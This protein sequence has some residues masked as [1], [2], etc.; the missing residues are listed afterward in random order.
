MGV[1]NLWPILASVKQEVCV[2][3]LEGKVIAVDLA[4]WLVESQVTGLKVMQ[5]KVLK[6]H[7]RNL[8]FRVSNFLRLGVQLV[9]VIDGTPPELKWE[10]VSRR[11]QAR[12]H[13]RKVGGARGRGNGRKGPSRSH[14]KGWLNECQEMLELMGVPCVQS[15]GEAEAMC[16][17]LDRQGIADG[18]L[19]EDGDAFLYGARTVYRN[20]NMS[21]GKVDRYSMDDI[22]TKLNLNRRRL[23]ALA[24][25]LGCDYLPKGVPGVG[26]EL[27]MKFFM[28]LP[29]TED[30]LV[31][32]QGWKDGLSPDAQAIERDIRKKS[33]KVDG[34]PNQDVINE[35]L[36]DKEREPS[37]QL[38]WKRP[39]L[40]HL[41]H[42]NLTKMDWLMEYTEEKVVPLLTLYDLTHV[43]SNSTTEC[44]QPAAVVKMRVR[45]GVQCVEIKWHKPETDKENEEN[46]NPYYTTIENRDLFASV[47][48]N[49]IQEYMTS[50]E[51][52]KTKRGK[53]KSRVPGSQEKGPS[54]TKAGDSEESDTRVPSSQRQQDAMSVVDREVAG[55]KDTQHGRDSYRTHKGFAKDEQLPLQRSSQVSSRVSSNK[56][57]DLKKAPGGKAE[58]IEE[59]S[60]RTKHTSV[61]PFKSSTDQQCSEVESPQS[62]LDT[63][64]KPLSL[65]ERLKLRQHSSQHLSADKVSK[66]DEKTVTDYDQ[67]TVLQASPRDESIIA[68][69]QDPLHQSQSQTFK[70]INEDELLKK[71]ISLSLDDG[72]IRKNA[73]LRAGH[74]ESKPR[75]E[76]GSHERAEPRNNNISLGNLT[77]KEESTT[78]Y[79]SGMPRSTTTERAKKAWNGKDK[80]SEDDTCKKLQRD[81]SFVEDDVAEISPL[82]ERLHCDRSM[83]KGAFHGMRKDSNKQTTV[84]GDSLPESM[85]NPECLC[86]EEEG[87]SSHN[88]ICGMKSLKHNSRLVESPPSMRTMSQ[89]PGGEVLSSPSARST[90]QGSRNQPEIIDLTGSPSVCAPV[91]LMKVTGCQ[92]PGTEEH[93]FRFADLASSDVSESNDS[94]TDERKIVADAK[95]AKDDSSLTPVLE[96]LTL[97]NSAQGKS[98]ATVMQNDVSFLKLDPGLANLLEDMNFRLSGA[99]MANTSCSQHGDS[100]FIIDDEHVDDVT[101][102]MEQEVLRSMKQKE[103]VPDI[104]IDECQR[105]MM[106][107]S[108]GSNSCEKDR[109]EEENLRKWE[110][111]RPGFSSNHMKECAVQIDSESNCQGSISPRQNDKAVHDCKE[112]KDIQVEANTPHT[113]GSSANEKRQPQESDQGRVD[114][115]TL[116]DMLTAHRKSVSS[117]VETATLNE[118]AA[119]E[120]TSGLHK[121]KGKRKAA[122]SKKSKR[123]QDTFLLE[124]SLARILEG[125]SP[126]TGSVSPLQRAD[127]KLTSS[128]P[129]CN[130]TSLEQAILSMSS[131]STL[132]PTL[133]TQSTLQIMSS[134]ATQSTT[135]PLGQA[136]TNSTPAATPPHN[137]ILSQPLNEMAL[138]EQPAVQLSS[139]SPT[140][141][142]PEVTLSLGTSPFLMKPGGG[143]TQVVNT[144]AAIP[145]VKTKW[146]TRP[147][148]S[149]APDQR[150]TK[151]PMKLRSRGK[152]RTHSQPDSSVP[153]PHRGAARGRKNRRES[154]LALEGS[155]AKILQN[156]SPYQECSKRNYE[157]SNLEKHE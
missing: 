83:G 28:S 56:S 143:V 54:S 81:T 4:I 110:T 119:V 57:L 27:A 17:L 5:G 10:E 157:D 84:S 6:P 77:T 23:V 12:H 39:L 35:F 125:L 67:Q 122:K 32:L 131:P 117:L 96:R 95:D 43:T 11:V 116:A 18:C 139:P 25:F 41:Q 29:R 129:A 140:P 135:R 78:E 3:A 137:A 145:D 53:N 130:K 147:R 16:A 97:S 138:S 93:N 150:R 118:V 106:L 86:M 60:N 22:E 34:F 132:V 107:D 36:L 91:K 101:E 19:T 136:A 9:F 144:P 111:V 26:K 88:H 72:S 40:T 61:Q 99:S 46:T 149:S 70:V 14:F 115:I 37:R 114:R 100:V 103:R 38:Q 79:P 148:I 128:A 127:I 112:T 76:F 2:Q 42:F 65:R 134:Q 7:L 48:P 71:L 92:D 49:M 90:G 62:N 20:L 153:Q 47:Y 55:R 156:M 146:K 151:A 30:I 58:A 33:L 113:Q 24:L 21:T 124:T 133:S 108:D 31:R 82:F 102:R 142:A 64:D 154:M 152:R 8:F 141:S 68:L 1:H 59:T 105:N 45:Q 74:G 87:E 94:S 126:F 13:G 121:K 80:I 109:H 52:K 155:L 75:R 85:S 51:G 120:K 44:L 123:L 89:T 63:N 104:S 98:L 69:R 66:T 73:G 50:K 15:Q